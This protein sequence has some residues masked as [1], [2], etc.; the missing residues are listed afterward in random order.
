MTSEQRHKIMSHIH[1]NNTGP[2]IILRKAL[3]H[4]GI[5]YRKNYK[6]L[7]GTPD[8]AITRNRIAIFVDGDFWHAK[9]HKDHPGEQI[10]TNQQ[11]WKKKLKL[12][13]ERDQEVND[14]LTEMGWLVLRFWTS[15]IKKDLQ[16]CVAMVCE[17]C[18]R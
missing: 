14:K 10:R 15:D 13:V 17:Y 11:Y 7:P 9:E 5:R 6:K 8:I 3:W 12:N 16:T 1:S 2:E 18:G 4:H